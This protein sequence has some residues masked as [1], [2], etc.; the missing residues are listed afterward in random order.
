MEYEKSGVLNEEVRRKSQDT[1]SHSDVLYTEDRG[2]HKTKDPRSRGKSRSKSKFKNPT[3][4]CC[5]CG[6]KG[7][8]KRF[9]KQLKQDLKEGKKEENN[10]N[11]V[12]AIVQDDLLFGCDKN[13]TYFVSEDTSWIVDFGATS[14]VTPRKDFFSCYTSVNY[15]VL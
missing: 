8:I 2:R 5:H 1:S 13:F 14:H 11:N 6:M 10:E 7:H 4:K 12:V 9:C 15:E 3:I